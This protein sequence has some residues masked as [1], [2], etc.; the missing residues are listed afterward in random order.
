MLITD[1]ERIS[2][3]M[4]CD[5]CGELILDGTRAFTIYQSEGHIGNLNIV[6]C[7]DCGNNLKNDMSDDYGRFENK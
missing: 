4:V 2:L 5:G 7:E 1:F 6:L 3:D